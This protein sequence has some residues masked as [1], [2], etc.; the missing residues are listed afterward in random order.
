MIA[1]AVC[2]QILNVS[3][4][5]DSDEEGI[6]TPKQKGFRCNCSPSVAPNCSDDTYITKYNSFMSMDTDCMGYT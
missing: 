5:R 1:N 3:S 6:H 4:G 2:S